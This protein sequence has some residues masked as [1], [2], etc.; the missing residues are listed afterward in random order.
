MKIKYKTADSTPRQSEIFA[1][2]GVNSI[3]LLKYRLILLINTY[4][5]HVAR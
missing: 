3:A 5:G 1:Q 4:F 2:S